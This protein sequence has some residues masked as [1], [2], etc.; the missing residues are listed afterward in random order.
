MHVY[1]D[2]CIIVCTNA[3]K[4]DLNEKFTGSGKDLKSE[5]DQS[6]RLQ[7]KIC[8]MEK[9]LADYGL[10]WVGSGRHN[11]HYLMFIHAYIHTYIHTYIH[12]FPYTTSPID[13]EE[14]E[15]EDEDYEGHTDSNAGKHHQVHYASSNVLYVCV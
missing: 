9:F 6:A 13:Y 1:R 10:V 7:L 11:G 8:E 14:D 4:H 3:C 15:N 12:V 2:V 5:R